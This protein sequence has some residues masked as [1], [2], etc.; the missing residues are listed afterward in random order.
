MLSVFPAHPTGHTEVYVVKLFVIKPEL[1]CPVK[2]SVYISNFCIENLNV[3]HKADLEV[4]R[5]SG[6]SF[7]LLVF[8]FSEAS[9]SLS[10]HPNIYL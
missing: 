9:S 10:F 1:L 6:K 4:V 2:F 3:S 7:V 5:L 8:L